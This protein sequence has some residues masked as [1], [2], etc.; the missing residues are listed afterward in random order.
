[1]LKLCN[2]QI[3]VREPPL[4][5]FSFL[6]KNLIISTRFLPEQKKSLIILKILSNKKLVICRTK[7]AQQKINY[8]QQDLPNN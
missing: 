7:S 6:F 3:E 4:S 5:F 8:F 1:L 2:I